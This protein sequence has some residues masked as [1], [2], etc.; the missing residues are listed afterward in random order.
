MKNKTEKALPKTMPG[1]I[2]VQYVRC[3][4]RTCKC[5]RGELHG[6]YFYHFARVNGKLTKRYLKAHEVEQM[7]IACMAWRE[8]EKARRARS[9]ET[10]QLIREMKAR[11]RDVLQQVDSFTR[12]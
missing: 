11:L 1:S 10:W 6:A 4:K 5:A 9:R 2:H 7:Q 8:E 3:G 12:G